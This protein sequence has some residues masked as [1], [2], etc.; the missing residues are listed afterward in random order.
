MMRLAED[1]VMFTIARF[2]KRVGHLQSRSEIP[3]S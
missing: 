2:G 1:G 3:P